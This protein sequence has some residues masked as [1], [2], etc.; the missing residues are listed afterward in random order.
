MDIWIQL[1]SLSAC[2]TQAQGLLSAVRQ[3]EFTHIHIPGK[4]YDSKIW[5][6][7]HPEG[8]MLR[9][10]VKGRRNSQNWGLLGLH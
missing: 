4:D 2:Q 6:L 5:A 10:G 1:K 3:E 8:Q 7:Q 9:G